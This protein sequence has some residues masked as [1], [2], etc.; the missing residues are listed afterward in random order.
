MQFKGYTRSQRTISESLWGDWCRETQSWPEQREFAE[1]WVALM[2]T[3]AKERRCQVRHMADSTMREAKREVPS[4]TEA[5]VR[6]VVWIL[7]GVWYLG[8]SLRN[9]AVER[10]GIL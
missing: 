9:W 5:Q 3:L 4:L 6:E 8:T 10:S 2:E 7:C 1:I